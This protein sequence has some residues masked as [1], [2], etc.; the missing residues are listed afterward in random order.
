MS[1]AQEIADNRIARISETASQLLAENKELVQVNALLQE[2]NVLLRN[3]VEELQVSLASELTREENL[4]AQ[5]E[6]LQLELLQNLG[7]YTAP[8]STKRTRRNVSPTPFTPNRNVTNQYPFL[9]LPALAQVEPTSGTM[10]V[11]YGQLPYTQLPYGQQQSSYA[12]QPYRQEEYRAQEYQPQQQT[13]LMIEE[14]K[15]NEYVNL[16]NEFIV[17]Y[18]EP[19]YENE[20]RNATQKR[21][22][23]TGL[24]FVVHPSRNLGGCSANLA[25]TWEQ[26]LQSSLAPSVREDF[27]RNVLQPLFSLPSSAQI[28]EQLFNW[29]E[30]KLQLR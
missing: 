20:L 5:L 17:N 10:M 29:A 21:R 7:Y 28:C 13:Q 1:R 9:M 4:E 25:T 12:V 14:T 18:L 24:A 8:P 27:Q 30:I 19:F 15:G 26:F 22:F 16:A 6:S 11:P 3:K 2:E 23:A